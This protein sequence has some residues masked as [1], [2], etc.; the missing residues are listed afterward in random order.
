MVLNTFTRRKRKWNRAFTTI[1][2]EN[3]SCMSPD[4]KK[5][6][7][8]FDFMTKKRRNQ[9]ELNGYTFLYGDTSIHIHPENADKNH[10]CLSLHLCLNGWSYKLIR[11]L[12]AIKKSTHI[13]QSEYTQNS[14]ND[15]FSAF[16]WM[17]YVKLL[18]SL[19]P[20]SYHILLYTY[21]LQHKIG[22]K[23]VYSHY[24]ITLNN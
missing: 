24:P 17:T 15:H 16:W 4:L 13:N 1:I 10:L 2:D 3:K 12:H 18:G 14:Q 21:G 20:T 9:S 19:V 7:V 6:Y 22:K 5:L 8:D 23:C 11:F